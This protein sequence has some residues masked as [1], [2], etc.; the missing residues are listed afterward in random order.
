M[1]CLQRMNKEETK[2]V[3]TCNVMRGTRKITSCAF[4][5]Q[6]L[7]LTFKLEREPMQSEVR[8][9]AAADSSVTCTEQMFVQ[10]TLE[11]ARCKLALHLCPQFYIYACKG[12][13]FGD[14]FFFS[15]LK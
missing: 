15:P 9:D 10:A 11:T 12:C 3:L 14:L 1:G 6:G 4:T 2:L 8:Y 7:L 5:E 13:S